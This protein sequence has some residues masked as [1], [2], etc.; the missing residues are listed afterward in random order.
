MQDFP[1]ETESDYIAVPTFPTADGLPTCATELG[2]SNVTTENMFSLPES[3]RGS[4]E[5]KELNIPGP[6]E[7][8][9]FSSFIQESTQPHNTSP[10]QYLSHV[11]VER[12]T[13]PHEKS[14]VNKGYLCPGTEV[15]DDL[16]KSGEEEQLFSDYLFC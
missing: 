2:F 12:T 1:Q 10:A 7:E 8:V 15:S 5:R 13:P 11:K 14:R 16:A 6:Y 4:V 3:P 9:D